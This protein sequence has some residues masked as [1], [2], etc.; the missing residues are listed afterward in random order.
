MSVSVTYAA[1]CTVAETLATDYNESATLNAASTPPVTMVAE[2][3]ATLSGG[4]LAINLESLTGTNGA[5]VVGTGLK[6][7]VV[8]VKNLGAN[9]LTVKSAASNGHTGI[10]AATTPHPIQP[11][12]HIQLFSNDNGDDIDSSHCTWTLTGTT[13][14]TSEW[15]IVLG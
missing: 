11:G 3:L 15:T 10:F 13:T 2:F 6:V 14:Q 1:T 5:T 12:G 7:Q 9:L 8:R 4:T